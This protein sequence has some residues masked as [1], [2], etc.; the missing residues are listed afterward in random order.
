MDN[1][2]FCR[3]DSNCDP[4]S[5]CRGNLFG[6]IKGKCVSKKG[7]C[8]FDS[9]CPRYYQCVGNQGGLI[10]GKCLLAISKSNPMSKSVGHISTSLLDPASQYRRTH[11]VNFALILIIFLTLGGISYF[12]YISF[13]K[14][15]YSPSSPGGCLTSSDCTVKGPGG[16]DISFQCGKRIYT[17]VP[18]KVSAGKTVTMSKLIGVKPNICDCTIL[19][20]GGYSSQYQMYKD[21]ALAGNPSNTNW[22]FNTGGNEL[23]SAANCK[24]YKNPDDGNFTKPLLNTLTPLK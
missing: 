10:E 4:T 14:P 21:S 20:G 1:I 19:Q 22:M 18:Y 15:I 23:L 6:L 24:F 5:K 12:I 16:K 17:Q 13:I 7:S 11:T 2:K 3:F 9:S 8:R